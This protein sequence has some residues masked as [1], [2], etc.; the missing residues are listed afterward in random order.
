M[1]KNNLPE[2]YLDLDRTLFKTSEF[3]GEVW[4]VI[5]EVNDGV[6]SSAELS[7]LADFYIENQDDDDY[8]DYD[9]SKHLKAVGLPVAEVYGLIR[10]RLKSDNFEHSGVSRLL[11]R[12]DELGLAVKIFTYGR[13]D[14]QKLKFDLSPFLAEYELITTLKPKHTF[15]EELA[16]KAIL[17][18]DKPIGEQMP[19][20]VTFVQS[21]GYN[22]VEPSDEFD[23][24]TV[25]SLEEFADVVEGLISGDKNV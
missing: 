15:F 14:F 13:D 8:R 21:I 19:D 25:S 18:D 7:R 10:D 1:P 12:L 20:N 9:F 5:G 17:L 23:W 24:Q 6:D 4:Q 16:Q 3:I 11:R 22:G 2:I